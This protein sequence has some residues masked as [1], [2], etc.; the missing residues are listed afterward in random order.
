MWHID[1]GSCAVFN[2]ID[3]DYNKQ[4]DQNDSDMGWEYFCVLLF[5]YVV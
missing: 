5:N 3:Q 4:D 2:L 1:R